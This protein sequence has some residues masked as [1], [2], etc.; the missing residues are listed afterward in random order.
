[1]YNYVKDLNNKF[2]EKLG[3]EKSM[4]NFELFLEK[5]FT[6]TT[7]LTNSIK[8]IKYS[9]YLSKFAKWLV[10]SNWESLKKQLFCKHNRK[11]YV[12]EARITGCKD[13]RKVLSVV[14][15]NQ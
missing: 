8:Y 12:P 15:N 1:M 7:K 14:K 10:P 13:C 5:I 9:F 2:L 6:F 11:F 4:A 3:S